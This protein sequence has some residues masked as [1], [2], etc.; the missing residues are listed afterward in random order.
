MVK[1]RQRRAEDMI[2][3]ASQSTCDLT[4]SDLR[5]R[6]FG[7]NNLWYQSPEGFAPEAPERTLPSLGS[8]LVAS[9]RIA[10]RV[11]RSDPNMS[12]ILVIFTVSG[13]F[14]TSYFRSATLDRKKFSKNIRSKHSHFSIPSDNALN[15]LKIPKDYTDE[16]AN[17]CAIGFLRETGTK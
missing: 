4:I 11:L 1:A 15:P 13:L 12:H 2:G 7:E 10:I 17:H 9:S 14:R 16:L 6:Q 8:Q 3:L 5:E